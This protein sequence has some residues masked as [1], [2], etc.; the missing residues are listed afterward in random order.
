VPVLYIY[1]TED[2]ALGRKAADLTRRYVTGPYQYKVL[3]G[4][5]HWLPEANPDVV[6]RE[7]IAHAGRFGRR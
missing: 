1:G 7:V 6:A 3:E 2:F 5:G 4:A